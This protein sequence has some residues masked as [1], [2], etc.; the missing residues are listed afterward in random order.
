[1][2][3]FI[4]FVPLMWLL[5]GRRTILVPLKR[6]RNKLENLRNWNL[7]LPNGE[8][9][10]PA[11]VQLMV[12]IGRVRGWPTGTLLLPT[13]NRPLNAKPRNLSV[14]NQLLNI[15]DWWIGCVFLFCCCSA[16][17]T[18]CNSNEH[19]RL[20]NCRLNAKPQQSVSGEPASDYWKIDEL[21]VSSCSAEL[22]PIAMAS[23]R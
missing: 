23:C 7:S 22:P 1:M 21:A 17:I 15:E 16:R 18:H 3:K 8:E 10:S 20:M 12:R 9:T 13:L 14:A 5:L 2:Q 19:R 11:F 4:I 6:R